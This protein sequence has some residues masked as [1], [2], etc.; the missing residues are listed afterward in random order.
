MACTILVYER[1]TLGLATVNGSTW[2][3]FVFYMFVYIYLH[4]HQMNLWIL[5]WFL[6]KVFYFDDLW[7]IFDDDIAYKNKV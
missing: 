3:I 5:F 7:F 1:Y 4:T 6:D 2:L